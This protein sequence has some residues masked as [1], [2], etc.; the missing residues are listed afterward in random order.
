MNDFNIKEQVNTDLSLLQKINRKNSDEVLLYRVKNKRIVDVAL[1]KK[2]KVGLHWFKVI[3]GLFRG[4]KFRDKKPR[5][6]L[7]NSLK[8][9]MLIAIKKWGDET[10]SE[11]LND[12]I[13]QIQKSPFHEKLKKEIKNLQ[14]KT[15]YLGKYTDDRKLIARALDFNKVEEGKLDNA[16]STCKE[17]LNELKKFD[18]E[19]HHKEHDEL[20]AVLVDKGLASKESCNCE[21]VIKELVGKYRKEIGT[22]LFDQGGHRDLDN[23]ELQDIFD[24][25]DAGRLF[26]ILGQASGFDQKGIEGKLTKIREMKQHIQALSEETREMFEEP[27]QSTLNRMENASKGILEML[28]ND[29]PRN[30]NKLMKV[31]KRPFDGEF[32]ERIKALKISKHLEK[33][34]ERLADRLAARKNEQLKDLVKEKESVEKEMA[35]LEA[36][37]QAASAMLEEKRAKRE[38]IKAIH[39]TTPDRGVSSDERSVIE[40]VRMEVQSK[41]NPGSLSDDDRARFTH[42]RNALGLK[43][44]NIGS[45]LTHGEMRKKIQKVIEKIP[46][47]RKE[48]ENE[49]VRLKEAVRN[50]M[51]MDNVDTLIKH[52]PKEESHILALTEDEAYSILHSLKI[53]IDPYLSMDGDFNQALVRIKREADWLTEVKNRKKDFPTYY[54]L[55][56]ANVL[57]K[58]NEQNRKFGFPTGSIPGQSDMKR[59]FDTIKNSQLRQELNE[60]MQFLIGLTIEPKIIE[61]LEKLERKGKVEKEIQMQNQSLKRKIEEI[62]RPR[63]QLKEIYDLLFQAIE[64]GSGE[65]TA[66]MKSEEIERL[67]HDMEEKKERLETL[68]QSIRAIGSEQEKYREMPLDQ[69]LSL[70]NRLE[71]SSTS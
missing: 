2:S 64:W 69:L 62:E 51:T 13:E 1:V 70:A 61:D 55:G 20:N 47:K 21:S 53:S 59:Q 38:E 34:R 31:E 15:D 35:G 49:V 71:R 42:H 8:S 33:E 16:V 60:Y 56:Y 12:L 48:L 23:K 39:I 65:R 68:D 57:N 27:I 63:K 3:G 4:M 24:R 5:R 11:E 36:K 7:E 10:L 17:L 54:N 22:Y 44:V 6:L 26:G 37:M 28:L 19:T 14:V 45:V 66:W 46:E 50:T 29:V 43:E 67:K 58:V 41:Q 52:I 30:V 18:E 25:R 40:M 9:D 32:G